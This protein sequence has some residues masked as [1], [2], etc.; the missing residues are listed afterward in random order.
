MNA[1]ST[2]GLGDGVCREHAGA[3]VIPELA[4]PV[5]AASDRAVVRFDGEFVGRG[6]IS[7]GA[8]AGCRHA[9]LRGLLRRFRWYRVHQL[10]VPDRCATRERPRGFDRGRRALPHKRTK[11]IRRI[12]RL[13]VPAHGGTRLAPR[14]RMANNSKRNPSKPKTGVRTPAN[15]PKD[16]AK[17]REALRDQ[18]KTEIEKNPYLDTEGGE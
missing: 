16:P 17:A 15:P 14:L 9:W 5:G 10:A 1:A 8:R 4:H 7:A 13:E 6:H 3:T 11:L 2:G 12:H 18:S